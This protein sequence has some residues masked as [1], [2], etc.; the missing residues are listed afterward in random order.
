MQMMEGYSAIANGGILRTPRLLETIDGQPVDHSAGERVISSQT[1]EQLR[2]MLEGV[3]G[4]GGT[5]S[6]VSV[7]GLRARGQDRHRPEGGRRHLL[8]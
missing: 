6:E 4:E 3:L 1:S 5:A 2:T 8:R 7:P